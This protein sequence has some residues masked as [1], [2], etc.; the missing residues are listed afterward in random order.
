MSSAAAWLCADVLLATGPVDGALETRRL[1]YPGCTV[2]L[3]RF[4]P[5]PSGGEPTLGPGHL[6]VD[7]RTLCRD[8]LAAADADA[9]GRLVE[10]LT[11]ALEWDLAPPV[12]AQLSQSL[13]MAR[14][15]LRERLPLVAAIAD[16]SARVVIDAVVAADDRTFVVTGAM[17]DRDVSVT[18]LT[19]VSAEGAR[20]DLRPRLLRHSHRQLP[21]TAG[22][23]GTGAFGAPSA[24]DDHWRLEL[25]TTAGDDIE[26]RTPRVVRDLA[27]GRRILLA[28]PA[29]QGEPGGALIREHVFPALD[30]MQSRLRASSAIAH[31]TQFGTRVAAPE[32]SVVVVLGAR[33]DRLE[34]QLAQFARDPEMRAVDLVYVDNSSE[35]RDRL[36]EQAGHL[37]SLYQVPFRVATLDQYAGFAAAIDAGAQ[38]AM[39]PLLALLSAEALPSH[40]R[41]L[42]P[43]IARHRS[44]PGV[45]AVLP[46][47]L[48]VDDS[49][50]DSTTAP[51][52]A[53]L[54]IASAMLEHV[55]GMSGRYIDPESE[56]ADLCLRLTRAGS[57]IV[58][59]AESAL[60]LLREELRF[61][62]QRHAEARYDRWVW[63]YLHGESPR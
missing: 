11:G 50:R 53:C 41:W 1:P 2:L 61:G 59:C 3:M 6:L 27:G 49:L 5:A 40:P 12:S 24:L 44:T 56:A 4:A 46:V 26:V 62:S 55:G 29:D 43:L 14:D 30:L 58:R 23:T 19:A 28:T 51:K 45:G 54:V 63:A 33:L 17:A 10:F 35:P 21:D 20:A 31:V 18:S 7:L 15:A 16:H 13:L 36:H 34:H 42:S 25:R 38:L 47:W 37:H 60:Y 48:D 52:G 57:P 39:A 8:H 22:F 32:T 9:R